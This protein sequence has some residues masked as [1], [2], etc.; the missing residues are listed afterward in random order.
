MLVH[1][2]HRPA[3]SCPV[4]SWSIAASTTQVFSQM[5]LTIHS[6]D[7]RSM[8][9]TSSSSSYSIAAP[10]Q[11]RHHHIASTHFQFLFSRRHYICIQSI[12]HARKGS[13]GLFIESSYSRSPTRGGITTRNVPHKKWLANVSLTMRYCASKS[14]PPL[15]L[16]E[17]PTGSVA[18]LWSIL[19]GA[20]VFDEMMIDL[21]A[22]VTCT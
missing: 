20:A 7:V 22:L 3:L 21:W 17:Q 1:V 4:L 12:D 10:R 9:T 19:I 2:R 6:G 14:M 18:P 11:H 8:Y 5:R 13:V 16:K 15:R